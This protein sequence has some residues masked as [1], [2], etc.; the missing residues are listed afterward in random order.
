MAR[1]TCAAVVD[2]QL[3]RRSSCCTKLKISTITAL[4]RIGTHVNLRH[5]YEQL[6]VGHG[7][8]ISIKL[9]GETRGDTGVKRS[10]G[11]SFGNQATLVFRGSDGLSVNTKV[12]LN[13]GVQMT[14]LKT[15][16]QGPKVLEMLAAM[17]RNVDGAVEQ[18]EMIRASDYSVCLINSDFDIGF[19]VKRDKLVRCMA[20]HH[21]RVLCSYE[22]CIYPGVKIK[23][24][25]SERNRRSGV[26]GCTDQCI[27]KGDGRGEGMCRKVTVSVFQSGKVII[28]GAH[29]EAQLQAAYAFIVE[30]VVE[31][32]GDEFELGDVVRHGASKVAV[33]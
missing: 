15:V 11:G 9:A 21:P 2:M 27:G 5:L 8:W 4:G 29:T 10:T 12:F 16:A 1:G 22:P 7:G 30:D 3:G 26:C 31:R 17:L 33:W 18:P 23:F 6:N 20:I 24:M 13:G 25:W 19:R 32:H 14:G 28:T